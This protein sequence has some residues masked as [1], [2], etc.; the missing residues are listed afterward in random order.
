MFFLTGG[1]INE[2]GTLSIPS[3]KKDLKAGLAYILEEGTYTV[4][5]TSKMSGDSNAYSLKVAA[6]QRGYAESSQIGNVT[7]ENNTTD[8]KT[9]EKSL[10]VPTNTVT[11]TKCA[12]YINPSF[13]SANRSLDYD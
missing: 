9:Y 12:F 8:Y 6:S 3:G 13:A 7:T 5:Y 2:N 10:V 11:A 4:K 1:G